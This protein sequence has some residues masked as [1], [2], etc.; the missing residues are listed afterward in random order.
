M[1]PF[2][3]AQTN[4]NLISVLLEL[5]L[6]ENA[7][8]INH[9]DVLMRSFQ[10][11]A[12]MA[13]PHKNL[14]KLLRSKRVQNSAQM[15]S[16]HHALEVLNKI[17]ARI[18]PHQKVNHHSAKTL[19]NQHAQISFHQLPALME[20]R[21]HP[22]RRKQSRLLMPRVEKL[23]ELLLRE[24]QLKSRKDQS[25]VLI[26]SH[27]HA[28]EVPDHQNAKIRASQ[29]DSHQSVLMEKIH[30]A[31]EELL[32]NAKM[33][34]LPRLPRRS[35]SKIARQVLLPS[36]KR[37]MERPS[38]RLLAKR[39]AQEVSSQLVP[40]VSPQVPVVI[41]LFQKETLQSVI[42]V[43]K[44]TALIN[45]HQNAL[46]EPQVL[47]RSKKALPIPKLVKLPRPSLMVPKPLLIQ[48][49]N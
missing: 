29:K 30:H 14:K 49:E 47:L 36:L 18:T 32:L 11:H 42:M 4:N 2:H 38:R 16:H 5:L 9:Q 33:V 24:Y 34:Q 13:K 15:E 35:L 1:D 8:T 40:M 43:E 6:K 22:K 10:T 48:P 39:N 27:H 19:L 31:L 45:Y 7:Q 37:K 28:L 17:C 12:R 25:F 21:L 41:N 26:T 46:M 44:Q 23:L 3:C 20:V